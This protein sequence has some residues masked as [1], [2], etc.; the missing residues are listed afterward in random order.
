MTNKIK[1]TKAREI[2]ETKKITLLSCIQVTKY[3]N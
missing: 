3:L 2:D 1:E